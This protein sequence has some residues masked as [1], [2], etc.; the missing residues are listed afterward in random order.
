[1][2]V[3]AVDMQTMIP[4]VGEVGRMQQEAQ[5][6]PLALQHVQTA[7]VQSAAERAQHQ[8]GEKPAPQ[9]VAARKDGD[10]GEGQG[11]ARRE[12]QGRR[13]KGQAGQEPKAEAPRQPGLGQRL[14]V[15]L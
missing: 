2:T 13:A 14:D 15:K 8:V 6:R 3:R 12:P 7:L 1:M 4:R 9:K 10:G 11:G 5:T